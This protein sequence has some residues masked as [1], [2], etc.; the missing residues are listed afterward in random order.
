MARAYF[1][2]VM[3]AIARQHGRQTRALA[4]ICGSADA[5]V[6]PA[7]Y[8][9]APP[10][11]VQPALQ[12]AYIK[13]D[14]VAVWEF[15]EAFAVVIKA[16]ENI[17]GLENA[18]VNPMGRALSLGHALRNPGSKI[19][20]TLVHKLK[21]GE[22]GV[23]AVCNGRGGSTAVVVQRVDRVEDPLYRASL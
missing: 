8:A 23:A 16:N 11:A 10:K 15:N 22:Y 9:V 7:D 5:G 20:V 18:R 12:R 21:I 6:D 19:L 2:G 4:R 13:K 3:S 1:S 17:L 14:D